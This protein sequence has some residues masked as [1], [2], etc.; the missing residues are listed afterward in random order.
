MKRLVSRMHFQLKLKKHFPCRSS[1][2]R[3]ICLLLFS[4]VHCNLF[5]ICP[6]ISFYVLVGC[7]LFIYCKLDVGLLVNQLS[8]KNYAPAV[9]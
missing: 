7:L 6:Y 5:A 3:Q 2:L 1:K 4:M 9:F 8:L